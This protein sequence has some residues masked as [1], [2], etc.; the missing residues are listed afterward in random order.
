MTYKIIARK[1]EYLEICR[2]IKSSVH[3]TVRID[4]HLI[5]RV[6]SL[7]NK[8]AFFCRINENILKGTVSQAMGSPKNWLEQTA[9]LPAMKSETDH[10]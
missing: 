3:P 8:E 10:L 4:N 2:N 1:D 7:Q 5:H 9:T 6:I